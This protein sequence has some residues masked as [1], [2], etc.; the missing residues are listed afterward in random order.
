[1][2]EVGA[3]LAEAEASLPAIAA[4]QADAMTNAKRPRSLL[5]F[6]QG[7][8]LALR[9]E[10][11]ALL[12]AALEQLVGKTAGDLEREWKANREKPS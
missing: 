11:V 10:E 7:M 3:E 4:A 6:V 8:V 1:V 9:A 12:C 2:V 5:F